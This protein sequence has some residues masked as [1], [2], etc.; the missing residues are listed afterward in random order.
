MT[1]TQR[2]GLYR[3]VGQFDQQGTFIVKVPRAQTQK[4]TMV[5]TD[6]EFDVKEF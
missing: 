6:S 2:S 1:T 3:T 5:Q 4:T